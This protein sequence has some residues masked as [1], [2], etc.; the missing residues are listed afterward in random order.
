VAVPR[1][2]GG[3]NRLHVYAVDL[4]LGGRPLV[5]AR[6][7]NADAL[8]PGYALENRQIVSRVF[9]DLLSD[10]GVRSLGGF[11][12]ALRES[13]CGMRPRARRRWRWC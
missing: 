10:L 1:Y 9:P 12:G 7:S 6:G 4:A 11:F 3:G 13:C 2:A 5:G 8:G